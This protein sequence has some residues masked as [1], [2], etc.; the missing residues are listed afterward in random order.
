MTH[1]I[2]AKLALVLLFSAWPCLMTLHV[3][4]GFWIGITCWLAYI[5]AVLVYPDVLG[6][7]SERQSLTA[8]WRNRQHA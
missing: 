7:S 3:R 8:R 6:L 1:K 5:A 4:H 2:V